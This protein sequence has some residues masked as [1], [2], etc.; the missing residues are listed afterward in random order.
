MSDLDLSRVHVD[1]AH[2]H[3]KCF[4]DPDAG[5]RRHPF[6]LRQPYVPGGGTDRRAGPLYS[7]AS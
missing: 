6:A 1:L 4:T 5:A 7:P 3:R 2:E